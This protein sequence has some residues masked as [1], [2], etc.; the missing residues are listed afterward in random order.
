MFL[1]SFH[2]ETL[3]TADLATGTIRLAKFERSLWYTLNERELRGPPDVR[4]RLASRR[5]QELGP[6]LPDVWR[7]EAPLAEGWAATLRG[8]ID[9]PGSPRPD[10]RGK[11]LGGPTDTP[12]RR[13]E[14][15]S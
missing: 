8:W 2:A 9:H 4:E 1:P 6:P 12:A 3:V 14:G 7:E 11:R 10:G 15:G 13:S 5:G